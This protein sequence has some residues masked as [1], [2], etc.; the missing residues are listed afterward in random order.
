METPAIITDFEQSIQNFHLPRSA[1]L[2]ELDFYMDQVISIM[3]KNLFLLSLDGSSKFITSSMIN[4]YVKLGIIP[5]PH[6]KR[7]TKEHICYLFM[8][9]TLKSIIPIPSISE[10]I[11]RQTEKQPLF[12]VYDMF[13]EAYENML[14]KA[15]EAS[16]EIITGEELLEDGLVKLSLFMSISAGTT[17]LIAANTLKV[18]APPSEEEDKKEK[19]EKKEKK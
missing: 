2:P 6:K 9:C 4:N 19:K 17:Q 3:E 7:Y 10:I 13:C 18:I 14:K 1:E 16:R 8:I 12:E 15:A 11:R 5:P